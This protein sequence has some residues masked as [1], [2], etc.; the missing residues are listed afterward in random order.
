MSNSKKELQKRLNEEQE[1][2][3]RDLENAGD[4]VEEVKVEPVKT[5]ERVK[6]PVIE[7]KP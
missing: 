4:P 5:P 2:K 3:L 6:T 7:K 1:K